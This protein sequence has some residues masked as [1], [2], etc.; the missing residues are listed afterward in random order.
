MWDCVSI[1]PHGLCLYK[2][3]ERNIVAKAKPR[4]I[5][6]AATEPKMWISQR[7]DG[8]GMLW[9]EITPEG[10]AA[11]MGSSASEIKGRETGEKTEKLASNGTFNR[12]G[13]SETSRKRLRES[14]G[15][16][17]ALNKRKKVW[18]KF[19]KQWQDFS[20]SFLTLTLPSEQRHTD[21]EIKSKCMNQFLTEVRKLSGRGVY[22]WRAE[23]QKNGNIHFHFIYNRFIPV[24]VLRRIWNRC[25]NKLGYV[26]EYTRLMNEEVKGFGDYYERF[27]EQG[28]YGTL[29]KR[30][31]KGKANGWTDPNSVDVHSIIRIKNVM[32][33]VSKYFC[34]RTQLSGQHQ[35]LEQIDDGIIGKL[36]GVSQ[37]L[38]A[39]RKASSVIDPEI[40]N[41]IEK[42]VRDTKCKIVCTEWCTFICIDV[43]YIIRR[44]FP[45]LKYIINW[46]I[47]QSNLGMYDLE[48]PQ[49]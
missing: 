11:L 38:S 22:V 14:I 32:A 42:I 40:S 47:T 30:Y 19:S 36:W 21:N 41:E 49:A 27:K 20:L 1:K 48:L 25:T 5:V 15:W 26:D 17:I 39:M 34:K 44:N 3:F 13:F 33:Y 10:R 2:Q 28:S 24:D 18:N 46:A 37:E 16:I 4:A 9:P 45:G 8:Q 29:Y 7:A 23:K 12:K 43:K 35:E 6:E 31:C